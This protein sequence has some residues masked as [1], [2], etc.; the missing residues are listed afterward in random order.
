MAKTRATRLDEEVRNAITWE[1]AI[2]LL[3]QGVINIA[4]G[5][6]TIEKDSQVFKAMESIVVRDLAIKQGRH[7][8][9][10]S[11]RAGAA[12]LAGYEPDAE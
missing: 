1:Q 2:P 8:L 9:P 3:A 12:H 10:A 6:T 5:L 7:K 4:E 11:W